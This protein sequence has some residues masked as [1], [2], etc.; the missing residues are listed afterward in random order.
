MQTNA[1]Q[2]HSKTQ[3]QLGQLYS[4]LDSGTFRQVKRL[5]NGLQAPEIAHLLESSPPSA[6]LALWQLVDKEREGDILQE[7]SEDIQ[8]QFMCWNENEETEN[9][10]VRKLHT[11]L[12]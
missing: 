5:L 8:A 7:L 2:L 10:M 9:C 3:S 12:G 11:R 4:A 6:R 1:D